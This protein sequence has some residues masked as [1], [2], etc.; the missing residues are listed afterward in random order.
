MNSSRLIGL[1][2]AFANNC[3]IVRWLLQFTELD[4]SSVYSNYTD[5]CSYTFTNYT[6]TVF[7]NYYFEFTMSN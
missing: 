5:L 7:F 6:E 1:F 2:D 4:H 3:V